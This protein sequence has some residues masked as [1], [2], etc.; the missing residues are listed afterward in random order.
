MENQIDNKTNLSD[1]D[2]NT[3][4]T[5]DNE[6]IVKKENYKQ[7]NFSQTNNNEIKTLTPITQEDYKHEDNSCGPIFCCMGGCGSSNNDGCAEILLFIILALLVIAVIALIFWGIYELC[8]LG[9]VGQAIGVGLGSAFVGAST[10]IGTLF[11]IGATCLTAIPAIGLAA[12]AITGV[13]LVIAGLI[14]LIRFSVKVDEHREKKAL[15]NIS[16]AKEAGRYKEDVEK[17]T[18]KDLLWRCNIKSALNELNN[19]PLSEYEQLLPENK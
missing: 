5:G 3:N 18:A 2:S 4:Q 7:D 12:L 1:N 6:K 8:D 9:F 11:G 17:E 14:F 16:K 10:A 15:E 19:K 13:A